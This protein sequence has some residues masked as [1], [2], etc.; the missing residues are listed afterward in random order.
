METSFHRH[1]D[2][3]ATRQSSLLTKGERTKQRLKAGAARLIETQNLSVI[4]ITD[5]C[6][7]SNLS[8]G[9][10][11]RYF[12]NKEAIITEVLR[13]FDEFTRG[14]LQ[15]QGRG[16]ADSYQA[17]RSTTET[18]VA[19][20]RANAGLMKLL[21]LSNQDLPEGPS[22]LMR[23]TGEWAAQMERSLVRRGAPGPVPEVARFTAYA[24]GAM[25]DQTLA[26]VFIYR[27]PKVL[28]LIPSET[29]LVDRLSAL[30]YRAAYGAEPMPEMDRSDRP[31][32]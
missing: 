19:V 9:A 5:I 17:I 2:A 13:D 11:Y 18:Y 15:A 1:L 7:E 16:Q 10:F 14:L 29:V 3:Y 28:A 20:F 23:Q 24:I 12:Q 21:L 26:Y 31:E 4:R 8:Q 30:Q 25:V 22:I 6:T 32:R 27:D